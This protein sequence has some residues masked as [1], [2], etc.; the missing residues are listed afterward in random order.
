MKLFHILTLL[1]CAPVLA[2][3]TV[4]SLLAKLD[5]VAPRFQS[6][7][8]NLTW[9]DHQGVVN[10]EE[11]QTGTVAI[12]RYSRTSAHYV[13]RF[14]SPDVYAV[15][16]RDNVIERYTPKNNLIQQYDISRYRDIAQ[17]L[18]LLG[19]GMTG[20]DLAAAFEIA[21]VRAE[22]VA[23]QPAAHVDLKPKAPE[24]R[25]QVVR[26]EL[27]ISDALGCAIQ[28]KLHYPG[29]SYKLVTFAS[30]KLNPKLDRA[31]MELPKNA[32]RE[33]VQ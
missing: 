20:K 12:R 8:A 21:G 9:I 26:I 22:A 4:S 24:I 17:A 19:F 5:E 23:G 6:A 31:A 7:T 25:K 11:K 13:A 16:L 2:A 10:I 29:G 32:K 27:W 14:T 30:V 28:Q 15:A 33:K 18:M 1:A 3:Q